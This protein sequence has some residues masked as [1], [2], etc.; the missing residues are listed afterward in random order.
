MQFFDQA[1]VAQALPYP[2]LMDALASGLQQAIASPLRS[3]FEP[4]GDAST[5][6]IMPAWRPQQLMGVK[7]VSIWPGNAALGKSAVSGV[8]VLISCADGTPVAV[9]DGT[10]LTLRRTAA[11]AALAARTLARKNS[12]TLAILG[13]GSL[14]APLALAHASVMDFKRVVVWGRNLAK[15]QAV[16]ERLAPLGVVAH[17]SADLQ[18]TLAGADVVAAASTATQP[19][20]RS[21][22]V[23]PG[24]HLGLVGAFTPTMAEA[25][26]ALMP[27]A[28]VFADNREAILQKGGEVLQA[29]Q[30]GL[31][32]ASDIQAELA[33]LAA[34]P[35]R[36]WRQSDEAITVFK[37][38]GFAALDLIAAE[39][40]FAAGQSGK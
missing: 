40:V 3:H 7:L 6:L 31:M 9:L 29:L 37:S 22:W 32:A 36:A 21:E 8:Y 24:T 10:E 27:R 35:E 17:A 39:K 30:Q 18:A 12:Q 28:Q 26:P 13:T 15:A 19:F 34:A 33:E 11:A 14:S 23:L 5:V 16:V 25:E 4:N 38:V 1:A 2:A 20:I